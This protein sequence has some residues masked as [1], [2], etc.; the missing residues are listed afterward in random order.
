MTMCATICQYRQ[1]V[2][3]LCQQ[4]HL[5][6]NYSTAFHTNNHYYSYNNHIHCMVISLQFGNAFTGEQ[7]AGTCITKH[8]SCL[9]LLCDFLSMAST[10]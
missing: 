9:T 1:I 6:I 7:Q 8:W 3:N 5:M 4:S 2:E 10:S